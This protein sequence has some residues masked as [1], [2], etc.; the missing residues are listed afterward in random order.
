MNPQISLKHLIIV[1]HNYTIKIIYELML[2]LINLIAYKYMKLTIQ[3]NTPL[4]VS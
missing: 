4:Q 3:I 2:S 1:Y